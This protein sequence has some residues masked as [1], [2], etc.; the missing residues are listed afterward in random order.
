MPEPK[1]P[2]DEKVNCGFCG[3]LVK[4]CDLLICPTCEREGCCTETEQG[5]CMPCGRHCM[6]PECEE[7]EGLDA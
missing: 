7:D 5:G 1:A 2:P 6:C 3:D 4:K